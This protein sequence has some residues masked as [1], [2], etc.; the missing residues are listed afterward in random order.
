MRRY[1]S[2]CSVAHPETKTQTQTLNKKNLDK[3]LNPLIKHAG[4]HKQLKP[5]KL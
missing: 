1:N 3:S 4:E 2:R 5:I